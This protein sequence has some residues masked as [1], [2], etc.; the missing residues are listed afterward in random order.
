MQPLG[1]R[2]CLP[3]R[4]TISLPGVTLM[5]DYTSSLCINTI[6]WLKQHNREDTH[7]NINIFDKS[8]IMSAI[9][10]THRAANFDKKTIQYAA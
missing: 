6:L 3:P 9:F 1:L 4:F 2:L 7:A 8:K 10:C 5:R